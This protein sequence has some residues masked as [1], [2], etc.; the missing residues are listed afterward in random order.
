MTSRTATILVTDLV[1]STQ[2]RVRLGE[3]AADG[4]RRAHEGMLLE[5]VEGHSGTVVKSLGD[6]ILASFPSAA[7]AMSGAVGI[8]QAVDA[9]CRR[10]AEL[11]E[12]RIGIS[13]GDVAVEDDD[14]FGIPV[15]EAAR[16]CAAASGGQILV[17]EL[18]KSMAR[19]RGDHVFAGVGA[20]DLKGLDEP[21]VA[22][23]LQ[24]EPLQTLSPI[25]LPTRLSAEH[26]FAFVG[27]HQEQAVLEGVWKE[28][29]AGHRRVVL[30]CGEA[31]IGKTRLANELA[32]TAHADGAIVLYGSCEAD[33]A[34]PYRPWVEALG[35]LFAEA[36]DDLLAAIDPR[37]L[38]DLTRV[39]PQVRERVP[40]LPLATVSDPE[41]ERYLFYQ[42]ALAVFAS[43]AEKVP[44]LVVLDDLHWSD[45]PSLALLEHL[46]RN[47]R[48]ER[49]LFIG[50]YRET[51]FELAQFG[52][53]FARLCRQH[54]VLNQSLRGLGDE[55]IVDLMERAAGQELGE[56]GAAIARAVHRETSGNPFFASELLR[57]LT[58]TGAIIQHPDGTWTSRW[59]AD[60]RA[61]PTSIRTLVAS[62]LARLGTDAQSTL[63]QAS[64]IGQGFDLVVLAAVLDLDDNKVLDALERA[65]ATGLV[66][67]VST[68]WFRFSHALVQH[69][70]YAEISPT[71]RSRMHLK[72][73]EALEDLDLAGRRPAEAARHWVASGSA[74]GVPRAI[75]LS[76]EAGAKASEA[77]APQEASRHYANALDLL[78]RIDD[79]DESLRCE[80]LLLL[81]EAQC[82]AGDP[83]FR[84][85]VVDAA[86]IADRLGDS[87]RLIRGALTD[88]QRGYMSIDDP[89]R[90]RILRQALAAA[91]EGDSP[92]RAK[93]LSCL[94]LELSFSDTARSGAASEEARAIA[95]R[96][97]DAA[98]MVKVL[99]HGGGGRFPTPKGLAGRKSAAKEA[100]ALVQGLGDPVLIF[101]AA[102][103]CLQ[104]AMWLAEL[105]EVD[106]NLALMTDLA[107]EVGRPDF[108]W[109]ATYCQADRV[110]LAGD[111]VRAE[112]LVEDAYRIGRETD[113]PGT[114][115]MYAAGMEGV[116]W[117][118]GRRSEMQHL[119]A[120]AAARDPNLSI[121]NVVVGDMHSGGR[122]VHPE[123]EELA[124]QVRNL[125]KDQTWLISMTVLAD[126]ALRRRDGE[127]A[128][129]AYDELSPYDGTLAASTG[130]CRG[131]VS[132]FLGVLAI[133]L[134]SWSVAERHLADARSLHER[135]EAPFHTART[136]LQWGEMLSERDG[137]SSPEA[138]RHLERALDIAAR[139]HC[140]Q[141]ERRARRGLDVLGSSTVGSG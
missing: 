87:D 24:W 78:P 91:G 68:G 36:P 92:E 60:E 127:A 50:T 56:D 53:V 48:D 4:F 95:G 77:L 114:L 97:G 62:R 85:N 74:K 140:A 55:E 2:L 138:R 67:T 40:D 10:H 65:E 124:E 63:S 90:V 72:V 132:H 82:E 107:E 58:E 38:A 16:L 25:R 21:I 141:V 126:M 14:V 12:V 64:V 39:L 136:E 18:A 116:R 45:L 34:A 9:F 47:T 8:Q 121:L 28:A 29:G 1:G 42:G 15:V 131:G 129:L 54:G 7:A 71:R 133:A 30:L 57:H 61:L 130:V 31:G 112:A 119:L 37:R 102:F 69:N 106:R 3:E 59:E 80:L 101:G 104:S 81:A 125:P 103:G 99:M 32:R 137:S 123:E 22:L 128:Q 117:H 120:E 44:L 109:I 26:L 5:V 20:L 6:G 96:L 33:L 76:C 98:T 105:D 100:L 79:D 51:D 86:T 83:Q 111:D 89:D 43:L 49:L 35:H 115:T 94:S 93:L 108:R 75:D 46:V 13:G 73:A 17:T 88:Y 19:G 122:E 11:H 70:L 110:L 134:G 23:E 135:L 27:R 52:E 139:H 41:T 84:Q 118:Q 66:E 113:Q